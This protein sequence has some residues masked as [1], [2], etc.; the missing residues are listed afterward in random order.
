M[1]RGVGPLDWELDGLE[2]VMAITSLIGI[3]SGRE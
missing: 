3:I 2:P 1:R